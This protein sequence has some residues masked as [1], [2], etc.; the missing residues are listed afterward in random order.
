MQID[1]IVNPDPNALSQSPSKTREE[2]RLKEACQEFES[3]LLSHMLTEMRSSIPKSNALGG[4]RD[5]ELFMGMLD[6]ERA[7][8]WAK[9]DGIGLSNLL[10]QQMKKNL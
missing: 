3:L 6:Q 10:Y 8:E 9:S 2:G 5:E 4:G 7:K 1:G